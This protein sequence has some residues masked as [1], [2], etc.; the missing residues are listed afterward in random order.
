MSWMKN[1]VW[2]KIIRLLKF[3]TKVRTSY[4]V[5]EATVMWREQLAAEKT[6]MDP[7][8]ATIVL[9]EVMKMMSDEKGSL[10]RFD[11]RFV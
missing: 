1:D 4:D 5:F 2:I 11:M 9:S 7:F 3:E 10:R 6:A 8:C